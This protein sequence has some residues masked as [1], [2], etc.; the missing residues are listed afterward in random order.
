MGSLGDFSDRIDMNPDVLGGNP[1][2]KGTRL[3]TQFIA[4]LVDDYGYTEGQ[5]AE[6][7]HLKPMELQR[8]IEFARAIG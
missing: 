1:V 3:E 2:L 7:Y 8:A 5:A 6:A 4:A